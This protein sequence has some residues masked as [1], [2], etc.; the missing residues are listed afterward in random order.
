[1]V[2]Y[3]ALYRDMLVLDGNLE[4]FGYSV[5]Q[6]M[7]K[8]GKGI[9]T[10]VTKRFGKKKKIAVFVGPGNKGGD[11]LVAARC[12]AP[13]NT[14]HVFLTAEPKTQEA[15][16]NF[17][18]IQNHKKIKIRRV[19]NQKDL[20]APNA[21]D[22]YIDALVGLG[23]NGELREPVRSVVL[24]LNQQKGKKVAVDVPTG[25]GSQT[26]FNADLVLS[27]HTKKTK[28]AIAMDIGIP[29]KLEGYVG[30]G[31]VKV[32]QLQHGSH[33]GENGA[34]TVIG[35]STQYHGAPL[36]AVDA[37]KAF[38]DLIYLYNP[39]NNLD[40]LNEMKSKSRAFSTLQKNQLDAAV[41]KS[42]CVLVGPGLEENAANKTLV[43][44]LLQKHP[45]KKFVLD[46]GAMMLADKKQFK[47]RVVL[48]PHAGE[49]KRCF[50][51]KATLG[52]AKA[53]AKKFH[54]VVLLKGK[55]DVITDGSKAFQNFTGNPGM[56]RGGTGDVLAGLVTALASQN[57][58][59]LSAQAA[60]FLNGLAGDLIAQRHRM[61]SADH[62]AQALP[63]AYEK[64]MRSSK[65]RNQ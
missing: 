37:A 11:G 64:A 25:F 13:T 17:K 39:S 3:A 14:V 44:D 60:A 57:D 41:K 22:V 56:T 40:F 34:I 48:T 50:G 6:A 29:K 28:D 16:E 49:F 31:Q 59:F 43:N 33:K 23:F 42:D 62:V 24:W 19:N 5:M 55:T 12:L 10:H 2:N 15:M 65:N 52:N 36:Y 27:T 54:C 20:P 47:H 8:A 58:L 21:F 63:D 35:G 30:P 61:F 46:A 1:M 18:R 51:V 38:C 32:L 53:M 4:W 26:A 9:A 45:K 7:E